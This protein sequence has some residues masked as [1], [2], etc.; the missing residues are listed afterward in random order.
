ME[1]LGQ[2]E[3]HAHSQ[4]STERCGRTPSS[5]TFRA[6]LT[7][8]ILASFLV[9]VAFLAQRNLIDD[10][11]G[12]FDFTLRSVQEIWNAAN[13]ADFHPPGMYVLSHF[14]YQLTQSIRW[15]TLGGLLFLY[16][17]LLVFCRATL[18]CFPDRTSALFYGLLLFLHPQVLMWGNSV[19]WYPYWT[20][21]ALVVMT[22]GLSLN[23][24]ALQ[25]PAPLSNARSAAVGV[26]FAALFYL[27]YITLLFVAAF[28]A[29]YVVRFSWRELQRMAVAGGVFVL[30]V[31]PQVV[32]FLTVHLPKRDLQE[33]STPVSIARLLHGVSLS[34]AVLPWH[35]IG[36][37]FLA[38]ACV[39]LTLLAAAKAWAFVWRRNENVTFLAGASLMTVF[40]TLAVL[41]SLTG[42]GGKPRSF[43]VLAPLFAFVLAT[44]FA[45]V[46]SPRYRIV[47]ALIC[48]SWIGVGVGHL[49]ARTSTAK[50]GLNSRPEQVTQFIAAKAQGR[51]AVVFLH[52]PALTYVLNQAARSRPWIIVSVYGDP[53]N[54][55]PS[56]AADPKCVPVIEFVIPSYTGDTDDVAQKLKDRLD[57]ARSYMV[58]SG[59]QKFDLDP[60]APWKR[61]VLGIDRSALPDQRMVVEYGIPRTPLDWIT[62][63]EKLRWDKPV[64][65]SGL[66]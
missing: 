13:H 11:V 5:N 66:R 58:K 36:M 48:V 47:T 34:E 32:P 57:V 14:F 19:R 39:P 33:Y 9:S 23:S 51:C 17:G 44:G 50:G 55:I 16:A 56:G 24:S 29:A 15:T 62:L 31:L 43:I 4:Q 25:K 61:W 10:E 7:G 27:N 22:V 1:P 12:S 46:T 28:L 52:D 59:E 21:I 3:L 42:L 45:R 64:S 41:A 60:D 65:V 38:A 40:V 35:P 54:R 6:L 26:L 49:L 53:V 37:L 8:V 30:L 20:G 18:R 2:G 63:S